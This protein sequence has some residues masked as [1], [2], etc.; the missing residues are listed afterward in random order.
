ME[1][2]RPDNNMEQQKHWPDKNM[3]HPYRT[4]R[5]IWY[6]SSRNPKTTKAPAQKQHLTTIA[7]A[8]KQKSTGTKTA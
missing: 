8:Q 7:G 3:E 1:E 4:R 6:F 5:A 2:Q